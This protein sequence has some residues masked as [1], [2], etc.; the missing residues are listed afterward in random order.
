MRLCLLRRAGKLE[1]GDQLKTIGSLA[2][3]DCASL[4]KLRLEKSV[5]SIAADAFN[6]CDALT[7]YGPRDSYGYEF[8]ESHRL[9]YVYDKASS[10]TYTRRNLIAGDPGAPNLDGKINA[11]DAT[12]VLLASVKKLTLSEDEAYA[13]DV[14]RDGVINSVDAAYILF[15][16]VGKLSLLNWVFD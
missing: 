11:S 7:L 12:R 6:G 5:S 10:A 3:A 1:L 8:A 2:F 4:E 13:A 9:L 15:H 16:A 14:N